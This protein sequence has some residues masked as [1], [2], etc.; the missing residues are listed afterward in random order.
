MFGHVIDGNIV[1][2]PLE[3][4]GIDQPVEQRSGVVPLDCDTQGFVPRTLQKVKGTS[5]AADLVNQVNGIID[6]IGINISPVFPDRQ[7]T[8]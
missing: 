8:W 6:S 5:Q 7:L 1:R 4:E 3:T 2:D